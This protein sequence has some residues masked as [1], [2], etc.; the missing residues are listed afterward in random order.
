MLRLAPLASA[1]GLL[2]AVSCTK[3][4]APPEEAPEPAGEGEAADDRL[5][6]EDEADGTGLDDPGNRPQEPE[7]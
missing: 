2:L 7:V 4:P 5:P 1:F 6:A 3:G